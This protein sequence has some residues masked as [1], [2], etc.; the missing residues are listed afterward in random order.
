MAKQKK[1][2]ENINDIAA[3]YSSMSAAER[4][5]AEERA[6]GLM[7][8]IVN[9]ILSRYGINNPDKRNDLYME[10]MLA[11]IEALRKFDPG[12]GSKFTTFA[13]SFISKSVGAGIQNLSVSGEAKHYL[14]RELVAYKKAKKE[15]SNSLRRE[16]SIDELS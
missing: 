10:G 15:L 9:T 2:P 8:P 4:R 12:Y 16:P 7:K 1:K 14:N 13:F 3:A 5:E 11:G 6:C